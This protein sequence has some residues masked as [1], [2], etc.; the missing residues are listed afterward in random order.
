MKKFKKLIKWPLIILVFCFIIYGGIY[1]Y[2]WI[3]PKL[4]IN[5][6]K[7]YYFYDKDANLITGTDT[8]FPACLY[9]IESG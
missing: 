9:N 7:S 6:A 4:T 8:A 2:A 1:L 5:S 3:S